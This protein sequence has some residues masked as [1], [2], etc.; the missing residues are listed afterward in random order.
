MSIPLPAS[1]YTNASRGA[2]EYGV[3]SPSILTWSY[4]GWLPPRALRSKLP[5]VYVRAWSTG[6]SGSRREKKR[7]MPKDERLDM[8]QR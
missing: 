5:A 1:P 4:K 7:I 6:F 2:G 8:G 3:N